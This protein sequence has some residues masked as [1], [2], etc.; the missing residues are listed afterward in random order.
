VQ[1]VEVEVSEINVHLA[2]KTKRDAHKPSCHWARWVPVTCMPC[3]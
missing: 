1:N 3:F 2:S